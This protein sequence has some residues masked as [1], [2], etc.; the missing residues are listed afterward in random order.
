VSPSSVEDI[1]DSTR[2]ETIAHCSQP[3]KQMI[4]NRAEEVQEGYMGGERRVKRKQW[5]RL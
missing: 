3:V 1:D 2:V 4:T 5:K